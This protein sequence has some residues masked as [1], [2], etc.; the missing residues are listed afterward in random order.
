[1]SEQNNYVEMMLKSL[2]RKIAAMDVILEECEKQSVIIEEQEIDWKQFDDCVDQKQQQ[3]DEL[4]RLDE[5]FADLYEHVKVEFQEHKDLY[6]SEI[7]QMQHMIKQITDKSVRIQTEEERNRKAVETGLMR[8]RRDIKASKASVKAASDYY[9][10]MS[11]VNY[12]D[13][14]FMDRKK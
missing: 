6:R 11:K 7:K 5:G 13:P 1:M 9:K 10:V 12:V 8:T 2:Q 3:I 4:A 14:Q